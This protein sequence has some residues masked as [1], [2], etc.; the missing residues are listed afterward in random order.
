ME[1]PI[2]YF[3]FQLVVHDWCKKAVVCAILSGYKRTF[4]ANQK[5]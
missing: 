2:S 3:S 5:E 4:A 1:D